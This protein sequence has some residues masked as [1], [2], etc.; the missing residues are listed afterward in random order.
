MS[1]TTPFTEV[2][3]TTEYNMTS[4]EEV[5]GSSGT[6]SAAIAVTVTLLLVVLALALGFLVYYR[7]R[8]R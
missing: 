1:S 3:P 8:K 7:R 4:K 2:F 6:N 5:S